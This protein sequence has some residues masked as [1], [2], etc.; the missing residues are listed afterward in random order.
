RHDA[1]IKRLARV[2]TITHAEAP[3]SAS[4]QIVLGEATVCLPL[5]GL[6]DLAAEAARLQ[7]ELAKATEEID[8]VHKK[9]S[10]ERF[11][12]NAAPEIVEAEREKLAELQ[13][14]QEKLSVAL[15][16]VRDTGA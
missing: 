8:R 14:L 12:A 9:L 7:K 10:S 2:D 6:I 5:G 16:R 4:A 15:S 3:P 1:A 11:V 13:A